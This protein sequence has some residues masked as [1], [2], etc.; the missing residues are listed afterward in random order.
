MTAARAC[1]MHMVPSLS[2]PLIIQALYVLLKSF[3]SCSPSHSRSLAN[4]AKSRE[5]RRG[6]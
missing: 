3:G 2:L 4:L 5:E 6:D 1:W